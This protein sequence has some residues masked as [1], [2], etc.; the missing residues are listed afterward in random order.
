MKLPEQFLAEITPNPSGSP[1]PRSILVT[2]GDLIADQTSQ[3]VKGIV[4]YHKTTFDGLVFG[5]GIQRFIYDFVLSAPAL[6]YRYYLFRVQYQADPDFYY[7][8]SLE[9][10]ADIAEELGCSADIT[11]DSAPVFEAQLE[12]IMAAHKTIAIVRSLYHHSQAEQAES[13][14]MAQDE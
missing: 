4:E 11:C 3:H 5:H 13:P 6:G 2:L 7:P 14:A 8:L 12:R 10:D 1:S 9:I